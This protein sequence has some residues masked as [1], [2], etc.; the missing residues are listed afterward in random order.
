MTF[1]RGARDLGDRPNP[2]LFNLF[3]FLLLFV[4]VVRVSHGKVEF[5]PTYSDKLQSLNI[6]EPVTYVARH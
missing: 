2:R 4:R 5:R 1:S 6:L 3:V